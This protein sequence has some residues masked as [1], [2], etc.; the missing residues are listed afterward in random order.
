MCIAGVYE[1]YTNVG[2]CEL[3]LQT[4]YQRTFQERSGAFAREEETEF[5]QCHPRPV[6]IAEQGTEIRL[7]LQQKAHRRTQK[8]RRIEKK[9]RRIEA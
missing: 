2:R 5:L 4:T 7:L 3:H 9:H 1:W 6:T 8:H